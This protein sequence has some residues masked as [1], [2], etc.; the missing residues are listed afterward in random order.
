MSS[1]EYSGPERRRPGPT[2][3]ARREDH[4][5]ARRRPRPLPR[6]DAQHPRARAGLRDRRR[7]RRHARRL[8]RCSVQ[9]SPDIILMDLSLPAPG[10]IETTQRIKRELPSRRD[11]R[12]GRRTRTRTPCST[13]SRPARPRSSS[14]TSART[15]SSRSSAG[16]PRGEY[17]INDKVFAKP[18]VASRVLKEFRELA[19]LRPGGRPDLRAALAARG[20][21]PRQHRPGHDQ[22]AGRLR[23]VDQRA[24][25]QEPHEPASCASSPSTTGPRPWST[26][27]AR[28]GSGCRRTDPP[29]TARAA[30]APAPRDRGAGPARG[31]PPDQGDR[32]DRAARPAGAQ[33][34]VA[35]REEARPEC[36]EAQD[37]AG[38]QPGEPGAE[39]VERSSP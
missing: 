5:P 25:R 17:L 29:V 3:G 28:A 32:R 33:R 26:P 13:R 10:G 37:R 16:S 1:M 36:R 15:T 22:Q 31:R 7:G 39:Q 18:A 2:G 11:H 23:A 30:S 4:D 12:P 14:R 6:R 38:R 27:C 24:D 20:R 34:G 9:L 8:R 19:D 21:D 35:P